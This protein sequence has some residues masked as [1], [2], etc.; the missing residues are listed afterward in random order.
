MSLFS[1]VCWFF[2]CEIVVLNFDWVYV[3][4]VLCEY[5]DLEHCF[6]AYY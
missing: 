3:L 1:L 4:Y 6:F 2:F 5:M